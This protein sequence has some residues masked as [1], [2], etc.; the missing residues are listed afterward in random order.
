MKVKPK[1]IEMLN[2]CCKC[3]SQPVETVQIDYTSE[4]WYTLR[5]PNCT[6]WQVTRDSKEAVEKAWNEMNE[7]DAEGP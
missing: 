1:E 5:C 2:P 6:G 4:A 7:Q 3:H